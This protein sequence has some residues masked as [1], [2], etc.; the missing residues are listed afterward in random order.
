MSWKRTKSGRRTVLWL[1]AWLA[2]AI[3]IFYLP[4]LLAHGAAQLTI[5]LKCPLAITAPQPCMVDNLDIGPAL[6]TLIRYENFLALSML[7]AAFI[8]LA[9][10]IGFIGSIFRPKTEDVQ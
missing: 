1:I 2:I 8:A 9:A 10:V 6:F 5:A 7:F 4:I 3:I